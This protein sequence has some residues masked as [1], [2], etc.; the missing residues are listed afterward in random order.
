MRRNWLVA[1]V[2]LLTGMLSLGALPTIKGVVSNMSLTLDGQKLN[3][4]VVVIDGVSY[5]P[6]KT[7]AEALDATVNLDQSKNTLNLV[8]YCGSGE[9]PVRL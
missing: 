8:A 5:A 3:A 9:P 2:L 7:L 1:G 4:K 6:V